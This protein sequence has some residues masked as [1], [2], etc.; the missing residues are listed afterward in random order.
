ML[1]FIKPE[2]R[3]SVLHLQKAKMSSHKYNFYIPI[4]PHAISRRTHER[5]V[6]VV[7]LF[8][9][10]FSNTLAMLALIA[11]FLMKLAKKSKVSYVMKTKSDAV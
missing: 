7:L 5:Y 11:M 3:T 8:G 10:F 6:F 2:N 9:A 1:K 4:P